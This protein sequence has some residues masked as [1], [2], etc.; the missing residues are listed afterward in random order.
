MSPF[1]QV[2][3]TERPDKVVGNLLEGRVGIIIDN[4]PFVIVVPGTFF[5]M[6]Q[7]PE[8][9]Y[10]RYIIASAIRLLRLLS[11]VSSLLLPSL[12]IALT[13]YHHEMI[14]TMLL[15]SIASSG[16]PFLSPQLWKH[17]SWKSHSKVCGKRGCVCPVRSDKR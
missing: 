3:V 5:Q 13:T 14:P 11:V 12:Y 4:T 15:I 9:Y 1:P 10:Q 17:W 8:D 6:L 2:M 16:K 7:S